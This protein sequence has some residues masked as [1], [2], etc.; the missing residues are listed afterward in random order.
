MEE[1]IQVRRLVDPDSVKYGHLVYVVYICGRRHHA[2]VFHMV[3][4]FRKYVDDTMRMHGEGLTFPCPACFDLYG[5]W[6]PGKRMSDKE[7]VDSGILETPKNEGLSKA[8]NEL[9]EK[10]FPDFSRMERLMEARRLRHVVETVQRNRELQDK[11]ERQERLLAPYGGYR[12]FMEDY[13]EENRVKWKKNR[14][15]N[16]FSYS[17]RARMRRLELKEAGLLPKR[18][19]LQQIKEEK[20]R[21]EHVYWTK[22]CPECDRPNSQEELDRKM[23]LAE[24]WLDEWV[25]KETERRR[26][27]R[28]KCERN[29]KKRMR[30]RS[31]NE[32]SINKTASAR[33]NLKK[34]MDRHAAELAELGIFSIR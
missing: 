23:A 8:I 6:D 9:V 7:I 16:R 34:A 25:Q 14:D 17:E 22:L 19:T 12:R 4:D 3:T 1:Q 18:K 21:N 13:R 27:L 5:D 2:Q 29:K 11:M 15:M 10:R 28:K 30:E 32:I 24:K 20:L 26:K 33:D 31:V